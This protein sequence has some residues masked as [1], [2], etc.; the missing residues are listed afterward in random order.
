MSMSIKSA[1]SNFMLVIFLG[2][3]IAFFSTKLG[4]I[5]EVYAELNE[6]WSEQ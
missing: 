6:V 5:A 4:T 2:I 1:V 3:M